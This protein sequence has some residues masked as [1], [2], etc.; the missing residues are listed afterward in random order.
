MFSSYQPLVDSHESSLFGIQTS[1][2]LNDQLIRS[3]KEL[4]LTLSL[5]KIQIYPHLCP[6]H[7]IYYPRFFHVKQAD[8]P[9]ARPVKT[10]LSWW[11]SSDLENYFFRINVKLLKNKQ[12]V[13]FSSWDFDL[14]WRSEVSTVMP[15][16]KN[17]H[18]SWSLCEWVNIVQ[19]MIKCY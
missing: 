13:I 4:K 19:Y 15:V 17:I 12:G 16:M 8:T 14:F 7:Q 11:R 6:F 1:L 3:W 18:L 2:S 9:K 5:R 10:A